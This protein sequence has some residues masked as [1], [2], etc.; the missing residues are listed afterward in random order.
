M[1]LSVSN[2][3]VKEKAIDIDVNNFVKELQKVINKNEFGI[4]IDGESDLSLVNN[5]AKNNK[6][7]NENREE[8][9]LQERL[10]LFEIYNKD[11][12]AGDLYYIA[13]K[14]TDNDFYVF[15]VNKD[16][17]FKIMNE[18][19]LPQNIKAGDI[20]RKKNG[21]INLSKEE[22]KAHSEK[23]KELAKGILESQE[24]DG[25]YE[26]EF[27]ESDLVVGN[28]YEGTYFEYPLDIGEKL[29]KKAGLSRTMI[30]NYLESDVNQVFV[31]AALKLSKNYTI[32]TLLPQNRTK[33]IEFSNGEYKE[34]SY[35]GGLYDIAKQY[36]T[37]LVK[38]KSG[39][40]VENN[41]LTQKF[42]NE[43]L[44]ELESNVKNK[45][46]KICN[47]YMQE[48]HV[49][50][51]KKSLDE[52]FIPT[53]TIKDISENRFL[54]LED[55]NFIKNRYA[56]DGIYTVKNGEYYKI[57]VKEEIPKNNTVDKDK[58]DEKNFANIMS[59]KYN[60]SK[61]TVEEKM[62]DFMLKKSQEQGA[63]IYTGYDVKKD[64]YY[65][66]YYVEGAFDEREII[67][68]DRADN[69]EVGTFMRMGSDEFDRYSGFF[70]ADELRYEFEE[71]IKKS[72]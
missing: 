9:F 6:M 71:I 46:D 20:L 59:K 17:G 64:E 67:S 26:R 72:L 41:E 57:E 28:G 69:M 61:E 34:I 12:T 22:I 7:T 50:E 54:E 44:Q 14:G 11:K 38:S 60:L 30:N 3:L 47:D 68:K 43:I 39:E 15:T 4:E 63:I 58:E 36:G 55:L 13:S 32:Y 18:T 8:F 42:Q 29:G 1:E 62:K 65:M 16:I 27:T 66:D 45:Y 5:I 23:M 49:Y 10:S 25:K 35:S 70:D 48:G 21:E 40:L 24:L 33:L 19:E 53:I 51:V 31:N 2:S 37:I 52:N 56:G